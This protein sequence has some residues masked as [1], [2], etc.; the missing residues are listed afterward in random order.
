MASGLPS[1]VA[2]STSP[3]TSG[4]ST[5][6]TPDSL[7]KRWPTIIQ[8]SAGSG[9][10]HLKAPSLI[11][12]N[13]PSKAVMKAAH[14]TLDTGPYSPIRAHSE[15]FSCRSCRR[16]AHLKRQGS[17]FP[18]ALSGTRFSG[19]IGASILFQIALV[20]YLVV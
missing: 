19:H 12:V 16:H 10:D 4:G 9:V 5:N 7:T 2:A 8:S 3:G 6:T 11:G 18:P 20:V 17:V 1:L 14:I 15:L 13:I